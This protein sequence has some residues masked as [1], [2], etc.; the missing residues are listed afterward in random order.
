MKV[1]PSTH[2][3]LQFLSAL[4]TTKETAMHHFLSNNREEFTARC[5]FKVAQRRRI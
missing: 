3:L 1:A 5:M 2:E 4:C